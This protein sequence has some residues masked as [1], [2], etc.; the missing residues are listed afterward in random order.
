[1]QSIV[2]G[3]Q[4][5]PGLGPCIGCRIAKLYTQNLEIGH[6]KSPKEELKFL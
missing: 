1:M 4:V 2:L 5:A 3:T 6:L